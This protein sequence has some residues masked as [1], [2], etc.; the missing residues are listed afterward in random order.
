[1]SEKTKQAEVRVVDQAIVASFMNATPPSI[2]RAE[3]SRINAASFELG[4]EGAKT[5]LSLKTQGGGSET[6]AVFSDA[7]SGAQ[8][9][10]AISR[11]VFKG[12][13]SSCPMHAGG[14]GRKLVWG[15]SI[16]LIIFVFLMFSSSG[17]APQEMQESGKSQTSSVQPAPP[18]AGVPLPADEVF[19]D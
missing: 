1:M 14:L 9:L 2:F 10:E 15:V 8:A 18:R 16:V 17:R 3:L 7:A 5:V 6:I 4:N 11:A 12:G 19:G 13:R